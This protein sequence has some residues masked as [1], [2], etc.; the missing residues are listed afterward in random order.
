MIAIFSSG[1]AVAMQLSRYTS[2]IS[3]ISSGSGTENSDCYHLD[4]ILTILCVSSQLYQYFLML[5]F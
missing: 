2:C 4:F 5:P 3:D 1:I